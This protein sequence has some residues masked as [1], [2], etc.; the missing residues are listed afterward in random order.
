MQYCIVL[1]RNLQLLSAHD[2]ITLEKIELYYFISLLLIFMLM[3]V[4]FGLIWRLVS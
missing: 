4:S 2:E 1:H 3:L